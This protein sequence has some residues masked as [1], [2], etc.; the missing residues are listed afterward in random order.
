LSRR[1]TQETE[2]TPSTE[3]AE[4]ESPEKETLKTQ[5]TK[6]SGPKK[7]GQ[8]INLDEVNKKEKTVDDARKRKRKR[9]SKDVKPTANKNKNNNQGQQRRGQNQYCCQKRRT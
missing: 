1:T 5:Y 6:L 7:T 2:V 4:S 9:I 8:T 3:K